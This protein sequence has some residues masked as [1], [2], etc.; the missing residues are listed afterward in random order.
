M[1]RSVGKLLSVILSLTIFLS[2]V[3]SAYAAVP[4]P[5]GVTAEQVAESISKTDDFI[6]S[7]APALT[8][9]TVRQIV[10]MLLY[11]DGNITKVFQS[12]YTSLEE[13]K[14][15]LSRLGLDV[16]T[17]R[18]A[19]CLSA[20]S[21]A[22]AALS[23]SDTWQGVDLT[24]VSWGVR[25]DTD[26]ANL[27]AA[28]F[29][30][31]NDVLYMLFCGGEYKASV[32]TLTG[33]NGYASAILP[34][35]QML[36]CPII[37]SDADFANQ[38]AGDKNAMIYNIAA[39]LLSLIDKISAAP[40]NTLTRLL[41]VAAEYLR[42]DGFAHTVTALAEP[43]SVRIGPFGYLFSGTKMLSFYM[44]L[45]DPNKYSMDFSENLP[46]LLESATVRSNGE[47]F[48]LPRIDI[49]AL[50][51]CKGDQNSAYILLMRWLI[52][53]LKE[54]REKLSASFGVEADGAIGGFVETLAQK[55]TD[56]LL[57]ILIRLLTV[58][59]GMPL[60]FAWSTAPFTPGTAAFTQNLTRENFQ[61]VYEELDGILDE[62]VA[63]LTE[64]DSVGELLR[65]KIFTNEIVTALAKGLYGALEEQRQLLA[66]IG[67]PA[68]PYQ[69]AEELS[70][71][72]FSSARNTLYHYASWESVE[73]VYWGFTD[74]SHSGFR[75]ALVGVLRPL[76]PALEMLLANGSV[77]LFDSIH[78]PGSNGYNTAVIPLLEALGCDPG[79]IR[80][81][82]QYAAEKGT[83][84]ILTDL[85][86]PILTLLD[87]IAQR[88]V[89][90]LLR[91]LPNALYFI[92][93]GGI[94]QCVANLTAPLKNLGEQFGVDIGSALGDFDALGK[95]DILG[96]LENML[97]QTVSQS[98]V[99]LKLAKPELAKLASLGTLV[100]KQSKRTYLGAPVQIDTVEADGAAMIVTVL[101][102][103]VTALKDPANADALSGMMSGAGAGGN[104]MFSQFAGG[105][106]GEFG[107]MTVDETIEWLY[108]LF[109]RERATLE[110][111]T[112]AEYIP[113]VIFKE[114]KTTADVVKPVVKAAVTVVL[115]GVV[116][117]IER[118]NIS[119][120]V[121]RLRRRKERRDR[122]VG[123]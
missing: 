13:S 25:N 29:A 23:A 89:H 68:A 110:V 39:S 7:A 101:R 4:V 6:R 121:Y 56:E 117:I 60:E 32:L 52:E 96:E 17:A 123:A 98:D 81:Y 42:G 112:G 58:T 69:L 119:D 114:K 73:S 113:T 97:A 20:Y 66:V 107:E 22:A 1:K 63:D 3:L 40:A 120:M 30:P 50:A 76:R 116:L 55:S 2:S 72:N 78:I 86:D 5:E 80:A 33:G 34:L 115:V 26:F 47:S 36:E 82:E 24:G 95:T 90:E 111:T 57:A 12:A 14:E 46:K 31:F 53:L 65:E 43:I 51:E 75:T 94:A 21:D 19:E 83:D 18:L 85:V 71:G 91:I 104:P 54:N 92:N 70:G 10:N 48:D 67:I 8:G 118:K 74:G 27:L 49:D 105:I 109:F 41:P 15:T 103:V 59:E 87:D 99:P 62:A 44:F 108:K 9:R 35:L 79:T 77:T 93:N 45:Q 122:D 84:M 11:S 100:K 28:M 61:K 102:Y 64:R 16:S 37:I 106:G 88:P 38:A